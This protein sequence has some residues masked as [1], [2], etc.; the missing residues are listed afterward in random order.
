MRFIWKKHRRYSKY[1]SAEITLFKTKINRFTIQEFYNPHYLEIR[2]WTLDDEIGF[3]V[4]KDWWQIPVNAESR[5]L[6]REDPDKGKV[7]SNIHVIAEQLK[8]ERLDG[9]DR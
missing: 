4:L 5:R 1:M 8:K 3:R 9:N 2:K 6:F 7:P